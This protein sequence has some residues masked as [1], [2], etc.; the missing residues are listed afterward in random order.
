MMGRVKRKVSH[1]MHPVQGEIWCLHRVV[2]T[3]SIYPSNR[4]LEI[5]PE[6]LEQQVVDYKRNGF[7]FVTLEQLLGHQS[8]LLPQKR[9][10]VSFDDG[11]KDVYEEA[12]PILRK[13]HVPFTLYLTTGFPDGTADLWW[14]QLEKDRSVD[15][16]ERI[17]KA[18]YE[19]GKPMAE[20]MH[21]LTQSDPD[22]NLCLD[23]ALNW[24]EIKEMV[25]S[26]LCTVG[27]HTVSHPGLVRIDAK[28][29]SSELHESKRVIK[30]KLGVEVVHLS[31][32]HSMQDE[33]VQRMIAEA[34]Y[35]SA[36]LGYGGNVRKGDNMYCLNRKHII[37]D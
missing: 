21:R 33:R 4:D 11:F 36:T 34:G 16:F 27:S 19:S 9:V 24:A 8:L 13:H 5:T 17:M 10:N 32:P 26:G 20:E 2:P 7:S 25:D 1:L 30:E 22:R 31:Y 35:T 15:E 12:F 3:R 37:Q 23:L 6:Y 14:I 18:V 29:V 28:E